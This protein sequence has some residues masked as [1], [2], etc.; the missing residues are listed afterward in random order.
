MTETLFD[1]GAAKRKV[2]ISIN[3]DLYA[4]TQALGLDVS[5]LVE[6]A[7]AGDPGEAC[8][9]MFGPPDAA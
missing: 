7:L 3:G 1:P 4:R 8:R 5:R 9:A 2:S 6:Q